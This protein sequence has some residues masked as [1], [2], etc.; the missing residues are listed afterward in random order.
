MTV[1][2][3]LLEQSY[4]TV[5]LFIAAE[6]F[7]QSKNSSI[8]KKAVVFFA[9]LI[10]CNFMPLMISRVISLTP[11]SKAVSS[12]SV[13]FVFTF[14]LLLIYEMGNLKRIVF[15][16]LFYLY[17]FIIG[18]MI[19]KLTWNNNLYS[20]SKNIDSNSIIYDSGLLRCILS[21]TLLVIISSFIRKG[22]SL[23][24]IIMFSAL[25]LTS[26]VLSLML[27]Y[28]AMP[29]YSMVSFI[30]STAIFLMFAII[31]IMYQRVTE[32]QQLKYET[33]LLKQNNTYYKHELEL[34]QLS[35]EKVRILRHDMKNHL[36]HIAALADNGDNE[37]IKKYA[38]QG[39]NRL[40][41]E[42]Q[43]VNCGSIAIDSLL[44]HRLN[45][46]KSKGTEIYVSV[47]IPA[48]FTI[49]SF[50]LTAIL[51]NLLDNAAEALEKTD[52]RRLYV[53]IKYSKCTLVIAIKNT[54]NKD[55]FNGL[56]TTKTENAEH[57]LG[58]NSVKAAAEKYN[59]ALE[60]TADDEYFTARVLL[61]TD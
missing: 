1:L 51:G 50:D 17:E 37:A 29:T 5:D 44:N 18:A 41:P 35:E 60:C 25:M 45:E 49:D 38:G 52:D 9:Y 30:V 27:I 7:A 31:L 3:S 39:I 36:T 32:A 2:Y 10:M 57:G 53:R 6:T 56:K 24:I 12:L 11:L 59:G 58:L 48:E 42:T 8:I 15:A 21:F 28:Y 40:A 4:F 14:L 19:I 47:S 33:L 55:H 26:A 22:S 46:L 43:F 34:M 20:L 54:Y 23:K 16:V 61:Y 13:Y